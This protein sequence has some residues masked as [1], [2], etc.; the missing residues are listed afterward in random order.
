MASNAALPSSLAEIL[1]DLG[2]ISTD[3]ICFDPAPGRATLADVVRL[4]EQGMHYELIDRTLVEK[5]MGWRES[6]IAGYLI[7]LLGSFVRKRNLGL[8]S[9]S[10][11]FVEL[12]ASLVRAPDVAFVSWERLPDGHVPEAA[13]PTLIPDLAVEVLSTGNTFAEMSRKRREYFYAGVRLVWMIDPR[14]RTVAVYTSIDEYHLLTENE[15]LTGGMVLPEFELRL[16]DLF[17]EL[18]RRPPKAE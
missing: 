11:G 5:A 8:V 2:G 7:G 18:D 12:F 14:M 15:V 17:G 16:A 3:R 13:I 1:A 9:G 10:D 6:L 4:N